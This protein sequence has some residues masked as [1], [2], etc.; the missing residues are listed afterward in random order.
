[1]PRFQIIEA[2]AAHY[3][4]TD[5]GAAMICLTSLTA[6]LDGKARNNQPK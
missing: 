6:V 3:A 1:M 5:A 4:E 2:G